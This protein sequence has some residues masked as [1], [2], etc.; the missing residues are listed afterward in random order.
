MVSRWPRT[1]ISTAL[2]NSE[3]RIWWIRILWPQ[4]G[5]PQRICSVSFPHTFGMH[6]NQ[7]LFVKQKRSMLI[8]FQIHIFKWWMT[9]QNMRFHNERTLK[10]SNCMSTQISCQSTPSANYQYFGSVFDRQTIE[11]EKSN[12][13]K[14]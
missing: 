6:F 7:L 5:S 2:L 8:W 12:Y 10:K 3:R 14:T 1:K 4:P 9:N 11:Y 13:S